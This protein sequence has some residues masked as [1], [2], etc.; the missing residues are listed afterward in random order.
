EN[1]Y[2][3][4]FS[5]RRLVS[6]LPETER[7]RLGTRIGKISTRYDEL[8]VAYQASKDENDIPLS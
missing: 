2:W 1:A 5:I 7:L 4:G 6:L 3:K 8:S